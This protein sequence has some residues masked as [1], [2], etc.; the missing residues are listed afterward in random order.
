MKS[1]AGN[2]GASKIIF[3]Q[4][5]RWK[6]ERS[7][8]IRSPQVPNYYFMLLKWQNMPKSRMKHKFNLYSSGNKVISNRQSK[9]FIGHI[10]LNMTKSQKT[11]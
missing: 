9:N 3:P 7:V 1:T 2:S 4:P 11:N 10:L 6:E 5:V 8:I